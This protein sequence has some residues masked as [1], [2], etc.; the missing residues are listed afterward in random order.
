MIKEGCEK[1]GKKYPEKENWYC[2]NKEKM[3]GEDEF[4]QPP[5]E[6]CESCFNK[7]EKEDQKKWSFF[8]S[9]NI[10]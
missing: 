7:L 10:S 2:R 6:L 5:G 9:T 8:R 1:C 4:T 3:V